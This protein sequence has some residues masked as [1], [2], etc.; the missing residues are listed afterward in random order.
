LNIDRKYTVREA[1]RI[2]L[3]SVPTIQ[4]LMRESA[5]IPRHH[6][7]HRN[8]AGSRLDWSDIVWARLLF[9]SFRVGAHISDAK[10]VTF[11]LDDLS[12]N[13]RADLERQW[14]REPV[15]RPEVFLRECEFQAYLV[16]ETMLGLPGPGTTRPRT[17]SDLHFYPSGSWPYLANYLRTNTS[18]E[19]KTVISAYAHHLDLTERLRELE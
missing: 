14:A 5:L 1:A 10:M 12:A 18:V 6:A 19:P 16:I 7:P 13:A 17:V 8:P 4:Q 9:Y 15:R 3:V 2:L 11:R